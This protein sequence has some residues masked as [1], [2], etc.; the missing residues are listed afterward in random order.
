MEIA[1]HGGRCCGVKHI[2]GFH[3]HP[4]MP[5]EE[6]GGHAGVFSSDHTKAGATVYIGKAPKETWKERFVRTLA[7]LEQNRPCGIIEIVLAT[8]N[9]DQVAKWVPIIRRH[10]F[11]RVTPK[12]GIKNGNSHNLLHVYHKYSGYTP[13]KKGK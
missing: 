1:Y 4:D 7:F 9:C 11:R 3:C 5:A 10:G 2:F 6:L 12:E 8:N 13:P